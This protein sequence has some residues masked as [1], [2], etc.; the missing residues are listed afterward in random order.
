MAK[1]F[2]KKYDEVVGLV[3]HKLVIK[4]TDPEGFSDKIKKV[5]WASSY[6]LAQEVRATANWLK[7]SKGCRVTYISLEKVE[8][9]INLDD[10]DTMVF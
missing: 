1:K 10:L 4:F 2:E 9:E 6:E 5:I 3:P 8:I 7:F